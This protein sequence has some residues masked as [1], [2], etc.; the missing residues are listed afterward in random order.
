MTVVRGTQAGLPVRVQDGGAVQETGDGP[1]VRTAG[2][3]PTPSSSV[4]FAPQLVQTGRR[5]SRRAASRTASTAFFAAEVDEHSGRLRS[6][7]APAPELIRIA[8]DLGAALASEYERAGTPPLSGLVR[9][10]G[11]RARIPRAAAWRIIRRRGLPANA[12]QLRTFLDACQVRRSAQRHHRSDPKPCHGRPDDRAR[13][14]WETR[15]PWS[16]K[17][18]VR[19]VRTPPST[20]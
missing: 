7:E 1:H 14:R 16:F 12:E 6:L 2:M 11:D 20:S 10:D 19:A 4:N 18:M 9:P 13:D 5:A 3:S 8:W 17:S 15:C